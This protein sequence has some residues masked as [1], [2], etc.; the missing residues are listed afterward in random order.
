MYTLLNQEMIHHSKAV[1]RG[2]K[3]AFLVGD[4]PFGTYEVSPEQALTNAIKY[5]QHGNVESVK[6]EGGAEMAPTIAKLT[7]VTWSYTG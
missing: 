2:A 3:S 4:M 6:L 5:I 1:A 7:S